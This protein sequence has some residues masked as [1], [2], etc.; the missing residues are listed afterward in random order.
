MSK[1]ICVYI[2]RLIKSYVNVPIF[3]FH[4]YLQIIHHCYVAQANINKTIIQVTIEANEKDLHR[5]NEQ[6]ASLRSE[7]ESLEATLFDSNTHLEECDMKRAQ[8][9]KELQELLVKHEAMKG[10]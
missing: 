6:L 8:F 3:Y 9:E 7:K 5:L 4:T 2:S 10:M 1:E